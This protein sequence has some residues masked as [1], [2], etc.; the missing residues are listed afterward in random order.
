MSRARLAAVVTAAPS[1][2]VASYNMRKAIGTDRRRNP[3]RVLDV[4]HEIDAD[5]VAL[6]EADKRFGGRGVGGA[7]RADRRPWPLHA[8]ALRR[9][10]IAACSTGCRGG[11]HV[12]ALLKA[13]YPQ[14]R[15]ARQCD[16]GEAAR[17]ACSTV[18]ALDLPT[19]EPRGAVHGRAAGRRPAAAGRRHAP[20]PRRACGGGGRCARSSTRSPSARRKCRPILMGDTNEWRDA[21]RLPQGF[22]AAI[23]DRADR[24]ELPRAP[25]GRGARPDHRRHAICG[26]MRPACT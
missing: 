18:A 4:L 17:R 13:Q 15:L 6:Q 16:P 26:S 5:V 3:Q 22:R 2:T 24:P 25:A 11:K 10:A 23:P 21:R 12:D 20:R 19:L 7:A 14:H 8:G 9:A 1:I